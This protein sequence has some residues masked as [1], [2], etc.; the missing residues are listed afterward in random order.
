MYYDD[1]RYIRF[2]GS[3]LDVILFDSP[4][5]LTIKYEGEAVHKVLRGN[6]S[7]DED[8]NVWKVEHIYTDGSTLTAY[9]IEEDCYKA[10]TSLKE[11]VT[12]YEIDFFFPAN[13]KVITDKATLLG[14]KTTF[15]S[16]YKNLENWYS[17]NKTDEEHE[18]IYTKGVLFYANDSFYYVDYDENPRFE[19]YG[20]SY[21]N[22]DTTV[23]K[24]TDQALLARL[25][26]AQEE[27]YGN[28]L[29]FLEDDEL[30]TGFSKTALSIVFGVVPLLLFLF[31][32]IKV[33]RKTGVVRKLYTA[34]CIACGAELLVFVLLLIRFLK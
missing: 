24:I 34:L 23:W 6:F 11:S 10:F 15:R 25:E 26:K 5:F 20:E 4:G 18:L 2:D 1:D 7:F 30:A 9:Y 17:V 12:D 16:A 31:A 29:G 27:Y 8:E 14:E 21:E 19:L 13:N 22:A 3:R 32:L 28:G 33:I